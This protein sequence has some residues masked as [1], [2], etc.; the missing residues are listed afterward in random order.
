[1]WF[2]NVQI[3]QMLAPFEHDALAFTRLLLADAFK[4]CPSHQPTSSGWEAPNKLDTDDTLV[5]AQNGLML[6]CLRTD[7]KVIPPS[8]V[9]EL[10]Q[11]RIEEIEQR[12]GRPVS[13]REKQNLKEDIYATLLPKALIRTTRIYAYIDTVR[14]LLIV[15]AS[16]NAKV[17]FFTHQLRKSVGE[18]KLQIPEVVNPS[19]MMTGWLKRQNRDPRFQL[20]DSCLLQDARQE[21]HTIRFQK[22]ELDQD[23]HITGFLDE[24]FLAT[25]MSLIWSKQL[26][27]VMKFDFAITRLKFLD[28][29]DEKLSDLFTETEQDRFDAD[30]AIMTE[31]IGAFVEDLLEIFQKEVNAESNT[32]TEA[33]PEPALA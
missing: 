5:Y 21:T 22:H 26:A 23:E 12:D 13:R 28:I 31:T 4:P 16:S 29:I 19:L 11:E 7:D 8:M 17:D 15:D 20:G 9:Q 1:M 2:K 27:F 24:G 33:A 3:F 6:V 25:Q 14:Q 32:E 10:T 30:F 18:I